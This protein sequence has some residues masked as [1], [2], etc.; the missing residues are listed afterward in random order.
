MPQDV[1]IDLE[2]PIISANFKGIRLRRLEFWNPFLF[3]F[4]CS[5]DN[6]QRTLLDVLAKNLSSEEGIHSDTTRYAR[7]AHGTLGWI[8]LTSLSKRESLSTD[9]G[10]SQSNDASGGSARGSGRKRPLRDDQRSSAPKW[11]S[12]V[13]K[14]VVQKRDVV[15]TGCY[16][17]TGCIVRTIE[18][19]CEDGCLPVS[20]RC[21]TISNLD[22]FSSSETGV[23][24]GIRSWKKHLSKWAQR[25]KVI[26]GNFFSSSFI[27]S[28][29]K[30]RL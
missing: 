4:I 15:P 14:T 28:S 22:S 29:E 3:Y 13:F 9:S 24:S 23:D 17:R 10:P 6:L 19:R 26:G 21:V 16:I 8:P 27:E 5:K 12:D 11:V 30:L 25:Q 7:L 1:L 20:A 2:K 18:Y